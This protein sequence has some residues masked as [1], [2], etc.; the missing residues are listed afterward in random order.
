MNQLPKQE[1]YLRH[2]GGLNPKQTQYLLDYT[3]EIELKKSKDFP[4]N[5]SLFHH[6]SYLYKGVMG[7]YAPCEKNGERLSYLIPPDSFFCDFHNPGRHIPSGY[8]IRALTPCSIVSLSAS[9][10]SQ[11]AHLEPDLGMSFH[12][13]RERVFFRMF[14]VRDKMEEGGTLER[15]RRLLEVFP[16]VM[17]VI[18]L[19]YVS[20]YFSITPQTLS[21]IRKKLG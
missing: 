5:G 10:A 11:L 1:S 6:L 17:Q 20:E 13:L 9:D 3:Q 14:L 18:P 15:Y 8:S 4:K 16:E 12:H 19:K 2:W 21:R 7:I